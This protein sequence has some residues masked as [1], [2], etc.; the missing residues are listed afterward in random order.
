MN[1]NIILFS[2]RGSSLIFIIIIIY[3]K[4]FNIVVL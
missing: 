4:K 1:I 3:V 2:E